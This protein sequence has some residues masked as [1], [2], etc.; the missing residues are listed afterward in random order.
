MYANIEK[1]ESIKQPKRE[2]FFTRTPLAAAG[3][4]GY[5]R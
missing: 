2:I 3:T 4:S 1:Y 5:L